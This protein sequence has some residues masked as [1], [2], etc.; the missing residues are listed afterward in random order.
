[1]VFV[2]SYERPPEGR[3]NLPVFSFEFKLQLP[4][5]TLA[6]GRRVIQKETPARGQRSQDK[7]KLELKTSECQAH[8]YLNIPGGRGAW[9]AAVT[10]VVRI[11]VRIVK[12]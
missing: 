3:Y 8:S 12:M 1:M 6:S 7:L 9:N 11:G 2:G 4:W 10:G 5:E